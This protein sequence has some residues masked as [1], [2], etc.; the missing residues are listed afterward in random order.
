[1]KVVPEPSERW[2][3]GAFTCV[4]GRGVAHLT[5]YLPVKVFGINPRVGWEAAQGQRVQVG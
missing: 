3:T 1:L 5:I 4:L 2:T